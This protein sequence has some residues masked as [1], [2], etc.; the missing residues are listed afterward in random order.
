MFNKNIISIVYNTYWVILKYKIIFVHCT[1]FSWHPLTAEYNPKIIQN[2]IK[3]LRPIK[4]H[5]FKTISSS[6]TDDK[7]KLT[8][9]NE[10]TFS[11]GT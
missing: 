6:L 1:N 2:L 9:K 10:A 7:Q 11:T 5:Y 3:F 8:A 4:L